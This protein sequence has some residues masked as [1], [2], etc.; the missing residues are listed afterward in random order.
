M[1]WGQVGLGEGS[2]FTCL[3]NSDS[4]GWVLITC[5]GYADPRHSCINEPSELKWAA[6]PCPD[7]HTAL[8]CTCIIC[9][10]LKGLFSIIIIT[11]I[12]IIVIIIIIIAIAIAI[13]IA[14]IIIIIIIIHINV[15]VSNSGSIILVSSSSNSSSRISLHTMAP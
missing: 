7:I 10:S 6:T 8:N 9:S 12:I 5:R 1:A 14:I 13:A 3:G 15:V 4:G 2:L 11:I